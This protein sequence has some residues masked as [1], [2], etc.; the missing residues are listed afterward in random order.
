[1]SDFQPEGRKYTPHVTLARLRVSSSRQVADYLSERGS[2][3]SAPFRAE[4]FVL[5]S[6]RDSVGGGPYVVEAAYPLEHLGEAERCTARRENASMQDLSTAKRAI[7]CAHACGDPVMPT[8]SSRYSPCFCASLRA[9]R[10]QL[11]GQPVGLEFLLRDAGRAARP[12]GAVG[13][14]LDAGAQPA[15]VIGADHDRLRGDQPQAMRV[16]RAIVVADREEQAAVEIIE[17]QQMGVVILDAAVAS[18]R[19]SKPSRDHVRLP[20]L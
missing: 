3:R 12:P 19:M 5:Y 6:S 14:D 11:L 20:I 17:P 1:M 13:N 10:H 7:W 8:K 16:D 4:R 2:F 9:Q 18:T 15:P